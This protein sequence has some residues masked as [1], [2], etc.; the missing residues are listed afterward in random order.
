MNF[1]INLF[2]EDKKGAFLSLYALLFL[3]LVIIFL[4]CK[5]DLIVLWIILALIYLYCSI[6]NP[7]FGFC[8]IILLH[9]FILKG[10]EKISIIEVLWGGYFFVLWVCWFYRKFFLNKERIITSWTESA[11][12]IF[13]LLCFLSIIPAYIFKSSLL[14]WF[15][16]LIPFLTYLL[17]FM[18][19]DIIN[20]KQHLIIILY[21]FFMLG[22]A[23]AIHNLYLYTQAVTDA[24]QLGQLIASRQTANEP[25]F[26]SAIIIATSLLFFID[27]KKT[28]FFLIC[29]ICFFSISLLATFSRGYWVATII[30]ITILIGMFPKNLKLKILS[31]SFFLIAFVG[32]LINIIYGDLGA[33]IIHVLGKR[34][35]TLANI[36]S[37]ISTLERIQESKAVFPLIKMNPICGYGFGKTYSFWS[38][39]SREMPTW[40]VH[41]AYFYVLLKI[42]LVGLAFLMIFFLKT[43][44]NGYLIYK[45]ES[46]KLIKG[47]AIG[48][49]SLFIGM[50]PLS[51]SSPQFLQKDSILL[52]ACGAGIIEL[53]R[54]K[55]HLFRENTIKT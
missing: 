30:S 45:S 4:A 16:E 48:I 41:N 53:M 10:T 12:F 32:F 29:I 50:I 11:L 38:L 51:L 49:V 44:H 25:L 35:D 46:A 7:L 17:F 33:S 20:K 47:L 36:G 24:V 21:S 22:A 52:I 1:F 27:G 39:L 42:G 40:Y 15:R 26:F 9:Y 31:Y 8:N 43:I 34:F 2:P 37:D 54:R 23:I 19:V 5:L 28:K 14:N 55:T 18:V 13:I 3:D 6:Q